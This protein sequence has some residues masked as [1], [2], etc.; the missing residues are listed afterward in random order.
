MKRHAARLVPAVALLALGVAT[1][2]P[3]LQGQNTGQPSTKNG[4]W[5]MYTADLA[6]SKYSP[7]D[8]IGA[9]NFN[10]LEVAWRFKTEPRS[11]S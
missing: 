10:K 6:G 8:Q 4:E 7:L 5:P 11:A 3:R 2:V 9:S 1:F